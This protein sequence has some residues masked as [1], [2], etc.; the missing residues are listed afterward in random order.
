MFIK[1]SKNGISPLRNEKFSLSLNPNCW[2]PTAVSVAGEPPCYARICPRPS[3][4]WC[5]RGRISRLAC[6]SAT[7]D[8]QTTAHPAAVTLGF[9]LI[10]EMIAWFF[11]ELFSEPEPFCSEPMAFFS[12]VITVVFSVA[13]LLPHPAWIGMWIRKVKRS[14]VV[15]KV[16]KSLANAQI[17]W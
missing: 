4:C 5:S 12:V 3:V 16:S 1:N 7:S 13:G 17:L 8:T 14:S 9:S 2:P 10:A 6:W 15:S 11:S